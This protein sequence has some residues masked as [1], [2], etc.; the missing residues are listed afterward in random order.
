MNAPKD[1]LTLQICTVGL[2]LVSLAVVTESV[3]DPV[4]VT[5]LFILGGVA[6]AAIG[7]C[8]SKKKLHTIMSHKA[9]IISALTFLLFSVFSLFGSKAPFVQS[10]YGVYG[11]N[12]GFILY[13]FLVLIFISIL[14]LKSTREFKRVNIALYFVGVVNLAYMLWFTVFGDIFPW[15]NLYKNFLGTFGNP[16]FISSFFGIFSAVLFSYAFDVKQ[17]LKVRLVNFAL[18]PLT[19][20]GIVQTGSLQGK[21][22]FIISFVVVLFF[23]I[24][25]RFQS[26]L[27]LVFYSTV[28]FVVFIFSLLGILQKGPLSHILY[29]RTVSLRGQYWYAG[30]KMGSEN[31]WLGV[32]FDSYGD[33]YRRSRRESAL[34]FPGVDTVS[35]AAHNVYLDIFAFGGLPLFLSY[36]LITLMVL[37]SIVRLCIRVKQFDPVVSTLTAGWVSYQFQSLISINQIGLAI[38]GW[39]FGASII[40]LERNLGNES[41]DLIA[42]QTSKG[43]SRKNEIFTLNL[44]AGVLAVAGLLVAVPPLSADME[45]RTAQLTQSATRL[46]E[47]LIPSYLN[48]LN[49]FKLNSAVGVFETNGYYELARKYALLSAKEFPKNYESWKN[50]SQIR[51]TTEREKEKAI[52]Q[53]KILDPLNPAIGENR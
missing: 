52:K 43:N 45:W 49:S 16:N 26:A 53:M 17:Q 3:T 29:Q 46:E 21:L 34:D 14:S 40:A 9:P 27:P 1:I 35:N 48:P 13:F 24:R 25:G 8:L 22:L 4:N 28:L 44:K 42:N 32:G 20:F 50:I 38:W 18:L 10:M 15:Y 23:V 33:W 12:N 6:F 5:K 47:S 11:R 31:P 36:A 41:S 39:V 51:N 30:W 37:I 7:S 19:Y 2:A